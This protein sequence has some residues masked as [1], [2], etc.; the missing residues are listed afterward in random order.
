MSNRG[1]YDSDSVCGVDWI[2][3]L[4]WSLCGE[5]LIKEQVVLVYDQILRFN[6]NFL[7]KWKLYLE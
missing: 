1:R 7:D 3:K 5:E 4:G 2:E 6:Q